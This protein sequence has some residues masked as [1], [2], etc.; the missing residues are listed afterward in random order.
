[1]CAGLGSTALGVGK[2]LKQAGGLA[3]TALDGGKVLNRAAEQTGP[4]VGIGDAWTAVEIG[5]CGVVDTVRLGALS[6]CGVVRL[7][8]VS[9]GGRR[10]IGYKD[11][12][13]LCNDKYSTQCMNLIQYSNRNT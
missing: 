6:N 12:Y 1:M 7:G 4:A 11:I 9:N 2:T 13:N 5:F 8:A 10:S 3:G